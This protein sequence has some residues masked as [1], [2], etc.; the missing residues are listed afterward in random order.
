M[1][2]GEDGDQIIKSQS[3][4]YP[5]LVTENTD[6]KFTIRNEGGGGM[7]SQACLDIKKL[8]LH[9]CLL[10]IQPILETAKCVFI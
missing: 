6:F 1:L 3:K 9:H 5:K 4:M 8:H 7:F 10:F 2:G